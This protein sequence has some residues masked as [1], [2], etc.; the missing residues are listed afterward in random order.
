MLTM[1]PFTAVTWEEQPRA[2]YIAINTQ[3]L[4][5]LPFVKMHQV[6]RN[7]VP[8]GSV[9]RPRTTRPAGLGGCVSDTTTSRLTR[10]N[11]P[12]DQVS[13]CRRVTW[14]LQRR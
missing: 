8:A 2:W 13:H 10:G 7:R 14:V 3:V 5:W 11:K 6:R 4:V 1:A 12:G 9:Q